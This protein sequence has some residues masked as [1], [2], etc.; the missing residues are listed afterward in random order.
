MN[1]REERMRSYCDRI[2][3]SFAARGMS[4][5]V[6]FYHN[7]G[8]CFRINKD[9]PTGGSTRDVYVAFYK[10]YE[11]E[12]SEFRW[13]IEGYTA[14]FLRRL[15]LANGGTTVPPGFAVTSW[16]SLVDFEFES[17]ILRMA[18]YAIVPIVAIG[19]LV[20]WLV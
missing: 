9:T 19:L 1:D 10:D 15:R 13:L 16:P 20:W 5:E 14:D 11:F 8:V 3:P 7:A 18:T 12:Y 4:V 17:K 6:R 2:N